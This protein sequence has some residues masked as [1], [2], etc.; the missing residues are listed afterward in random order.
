MLLYKYQS[1]TEVHLYSFVRFAHFSL[2]TQEEK[3]KKRKE[4]KK[5]AKMNKDLFVTVVQ[6]MLE[7]K[8]LKTFVKEVLPALQYVTYIGGC[9]GSNA[10]FI[11]ELRK[12]L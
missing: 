1:C 6:E 12:N 8:G 4:I 7:E 10:S 9:C 5:M 2:F 11:A 3:Y